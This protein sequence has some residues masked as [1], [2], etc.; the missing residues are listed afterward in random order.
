[1]VV[2]GKFIRVYYIR[3]QWTRTSSYLLFL[4]TSREAGK[5]SNSAQNEGEKWV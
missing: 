5:Q 2:C 3:S 1:M 4:L